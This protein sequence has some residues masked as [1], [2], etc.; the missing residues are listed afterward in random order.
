MKWLFILLL[1]IHCPQTGLARSTQKNACI[2]NLKQIDGAVQ[3]WAL[4]NHQA[5][6]NRYSLADTN[7]TKFLKQG[8]LPQCPAGGSYVAGRTVEDSPHCMF[9][10]HLLTYGYMGEVSRAFYSDF[11]RLQLVLSAA[12][13]LASILLIYQAN[14]LA[15][16]A[17]ESSSKIRFLV[18]AVILLAALS[19][20]V[21]RLLMP[22]GYQGEFFEWLPML[23][24]SLIG[25]SFA[26]VSSLNVTDV[27]W[28]S[29]LV[30]IGGI[31]CLLLSPAVYDVMVSW[32]F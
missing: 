25:A 10:G 24:L 2:A 28:R 23:V 17:V 5:D 12:A 18:S 22:E 29:G 19:S 9:H 6:A 32:R 27:A 20:H 4:E 11:M 21:C 3:Q 8:V 31:Q 1:I 7:I 15:K 30:S 16:K 14:K 13:V 26:F